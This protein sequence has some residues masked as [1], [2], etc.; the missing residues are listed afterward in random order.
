MIKTGISQLWPTTVLHDTV[1]DHA[2]LE[3][4]TQELMT[5]MA[6]D[7]SRTPS[8]HP[9]TYDDS[10]IFDMDSAV[11][12][13]FKQTVIMPAFETYMQEAYGCSLADYQTSFKSWIV[14]YTNGRHMPSHNHP[15]S[16]ISAVFYLLAEE[17][18]SGGNIVFQDPRS[19]ANRGHDS[20]IKERAFNNV[21][22]TPKTGDI[23]VFPSYMYHYVEPFSGIMRLAMPVDLFLT[24][25]A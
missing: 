7:M 6:A 2:L 19:N 23:L 24:K 25:H 3:S 20:I 14:S 4:L 22:H 8:S 18:N 9:M 1:K 12:Q 21:T 10:N 13:K 15:D 5:E 16:Q 17:P 11:I